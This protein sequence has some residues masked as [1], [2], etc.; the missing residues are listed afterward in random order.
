MEKLRKEKKKDASIELGKK[1]YPHPALTKRYPGNLY[2]AM[3]HPI[4]GYGIKGVIWY[5]GESNAK[6]LKQSFHYRIQIAR[7]IASWRNVWKQ[8]DFPFYSVQLPDYKVKQEN[9]VEHGKHLGCMERLFNGRFQ[10]NSKFFICRR[11]W[12]RHGKRHPPLNK[13]L[14]GMNLAHLALNKTYGQK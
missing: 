5:Q 11:T 8:G 10:I 14:V 4:E 13:Q 9:P 12:R 6:K 2:N 1:P 7:M 3:I